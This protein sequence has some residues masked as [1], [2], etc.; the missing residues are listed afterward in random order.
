[1]ANFD[2]NMFRD[3]ELT[4]GFRPGDP[5]DETFMLQDKEEYPGEL[6]DFNLQERKKTPVIEDTGSQNKIE[7]NPVAKEQSQIVDNTPE[8]ELSGQTEVT[9][10]TGRIP[11][12]AE[13]NLIEEAKVEAMPVIS[14][15]QENINTESTS[16]SQNES[17][18]DINANISALDNL[19]ESG[20]DLSA[21]VDEDLTQ[22][23][24]SELDRTSEAEGKS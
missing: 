3:E 15:K 16:D 23:L 4:G 8:K 24:K 11:K 18:N 22:M 5:D 21:I 20:M 1:M 10:E 7:E 9:D 12:E 6:P 19:N 17:I 2:E 14:E 13:P